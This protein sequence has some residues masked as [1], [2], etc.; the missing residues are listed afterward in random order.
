MRQPLGEAGEHGLVLNLGGLAASGTSMCSMCTPC[1]S[2][3]CSEELPGKKQLGGGRD[4]WEQSPAAMA[5][6][7][8]PLHTPSC[9]REQ[10]G[11]VRV[12]GV[13]S[14]PEHVGSTPWHK[15]ASV[16]ASLHTG[17]RGEQL[18]PGQLCHPG[19][20]AR[21]IGHAPHH[22]WEGV[23]C[24][25]GRVCGEWAGGRDGDINCATTMRMVEQTDRLQRSLLVRRQAEKKGF[26]G[27]EL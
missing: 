3:S 17:Q 14:G 22:P 25:E 1:S 21:D 12:P 26:L 13:T 9:P 19:H 8:L 7:L 2:L 15:G 18:I 24:K 23:R 27:P 10:G 6:R 5:Q 20:P 4:A 16:R 11:P